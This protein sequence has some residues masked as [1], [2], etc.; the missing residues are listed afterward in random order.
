MD[1]QPL[2]PP[3]PVGTKIKYVGTTKACCSYGSS[4][5]K[6]YVKI[7]EIGEVYEIYQ[8]FEGYWGTNEPLG[9]YDDDG[10]EIHD[11][12]SHGSSCDQLTD[13]KGNEFSGCCIH[14]DEDLSVWEVVK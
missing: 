3:F 10:N 12:T 5:T 2:D 13:S 1:I 9:D 11:W 7:Y 14:A 8:I 6:E 4:L